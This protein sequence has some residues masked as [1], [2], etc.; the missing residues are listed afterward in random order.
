MAIF[1]NLR[2]NSLD[3]IAHVIQ[4]AIAPVFLLTAVGTLLSVLTNRLGRAVDR[5]RALERM[6]DSG[7]A[8]ADEARAEAELLLVARRVTLIYQAIVLAV[9][10]ALFICLLIALAFVDAFLATNLA[11]GLG[12]LFVLA[13]FALIGSL[14]MFL[15]EIFLAV[16]TATREAHKAR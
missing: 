1:S 7:R 4:L 10:C 2:A 9:F 8:G 14:L 15:R 6:L 11:R 16:S 3:D 12:V 5:R 13:M